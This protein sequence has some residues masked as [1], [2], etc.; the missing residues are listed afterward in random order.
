VIS[1]LEGEHD[2]FLAS[3]KNANRIYE[4]S[5]RTTCLELLAREKQMALKGGESTT[6]VVEEVGVFA[7]AALDKVITKRPDAFITWEGAKKKRR[8]R[9]ADRIEAQIL[10][11]QTASLEEMHLSLEE[12]LKE[13]LRIH[14]FVHIPFKFLAMVMTLRD[15]SG[16][17]ITGRMTAVTELGST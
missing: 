1:N 14:A 15:E 16:K 17:E 7:A 10:A 9:D 4:E 12:Y 3:A 2:S 13:R 11:A 6:A 8:K 5:L